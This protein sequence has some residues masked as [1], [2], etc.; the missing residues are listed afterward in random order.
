M[1]SRE[2]DEITPPTPKTVKGYALLI[3]AGKGKAET[4][5]GYLIAPSPDKMQQ[6]VNA[7]RGGP[8]VEVTLAMLT[9][10]SI[11]VN[12]PKA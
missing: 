2:P 12:T 4:C 7:L 5:L 3:T 1:V 6:L 10:A 8:E 11:T 9:G